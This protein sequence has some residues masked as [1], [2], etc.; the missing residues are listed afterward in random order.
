MYEYFRVIVFFSYCV[1][2]KSNGTALCTASRSCTVVYS[3]YTA[4]VYNA[5]RLA[6]PLPK[7]RQKKGNK[8]KVQKKAFYGF[9]APLNPSLT[10]CVCLDFFPFNSVP[11][12]VQHSVHCTVETTLHACSVLQHHSCCKEYK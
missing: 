11:I 7:T 6:D 5:V 10:D 1:S 2:K 12:H 3:T 8:L 4:R 9:T